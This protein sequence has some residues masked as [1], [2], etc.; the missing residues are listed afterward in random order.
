[1]NANVSQLDSVICGSG[2]T[3]T[4]NDPEWETTSETSD[5]Q[6]PSF[7]RPVQRQDLSKLVEIPVRTLVQQSETVAW[8]SPVLSYSNDHKGYE[9]LMVRIRS[10]IFNIAHILCKDFL[11]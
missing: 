6:P 8:L 7:E 9:R 11:I 5:E 10:F 1:M 2:T 3:L 4:S